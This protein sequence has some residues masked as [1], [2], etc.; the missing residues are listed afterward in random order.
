MITFHLPVDL[1]AL[2]DPADLGRQVQLREAQLDWRRVE[3][4]P[5]HVLLELLSAID[6]EADGS[7]LVLQC[8]SG[9]RRATI[10]NALPLAAAERA[11]REARAAE[12]EAA[13][14]TEVYEPSRK[15]QRLSPRGLR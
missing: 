7:G 3:D 13:F 9:D 4:A 5:A 8:A 14:F 1:S 2:D 15:L 12:A 6:L 11:R 10:E